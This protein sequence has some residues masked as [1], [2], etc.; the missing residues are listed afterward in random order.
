MQ[1]SNTH[2]VKQYASVNKEAHTSNKTIH[3]RPATFSSNV[4]RNVTALELLDGFYPLKTKFAHINV[5]SLYFRQNRVRVC[6]I[7][8][9]CVIRKLIP[10][11]KLAI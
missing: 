9:S 5:Q 1:D 3:K 11:F 4:H 8:V 10:V 7:T 2:I 6:T